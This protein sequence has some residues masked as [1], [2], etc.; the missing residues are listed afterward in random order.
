MYESVNVAT[1]RWV[2]CDDAK[3]MDEFRRKC[4]VNLALDGGDNLTYIAPTRVNLNLS[5]E[6]YP[7]VMFHQ[8]REH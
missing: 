7:E 4:E 2:T 6:R 5:Q 1:A 8:T 3:K